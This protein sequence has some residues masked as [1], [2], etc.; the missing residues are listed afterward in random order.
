MIGLPRKLFRREP[1]PYDVGRPPFNRT[2]ADALAPLD[3]ALAGIA[4][5][6]MPRRAG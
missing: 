2:G 4:R 6:A 3:L 5:D 1:R